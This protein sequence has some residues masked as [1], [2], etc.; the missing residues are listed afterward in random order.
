[1][2]IGTIDMT[3]LR[4]V[5]D[6]LV[7]LAKELA[8]VLVGNDQLQREG[9]RQQERATAQGRALRDEVAAEKEEMRAEA[10]GKRQRAAQASK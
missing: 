5:T 10:L 2:R 9:E 8:G 6:K 3:K 4:F 7:G 1:M